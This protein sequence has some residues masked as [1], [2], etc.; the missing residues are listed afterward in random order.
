MITI[1]TSVITRP[2]MII[3]V[4]IRIIDNHLNNINYYNDNNH[5]NN[6]TLIIFALNIYN[7]Y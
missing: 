5:S 4:M 7:R 1:L 6:L 2:I 3:I